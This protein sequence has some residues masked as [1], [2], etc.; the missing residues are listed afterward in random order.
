MAMFSSLALLF[1]VMDRLTKLL[2]VRYLRELDHSIVIIPDWLK[3]TYAENLGIAFGV[4]FIPP[5]GLLLLTFAI[6][7]GVIV[8]VWKSG[9]RTNLLVTS[10]ALILG[11]GVGN[12]IDRVVLGH[13][14]DFIHVDLYQGMLFGKPV[15]LWPIFNVADSC[16]T[17]GA[18]MLILF[19][20]RIFPAGDPKP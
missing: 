12:L 8:Y 7:I 17:I 15:M 6:S 18:C 3:L 20:D 10:F 9:N 16:I 1:A 14:V 13:V 19:H 5:Q 4:R 11:G 2:A